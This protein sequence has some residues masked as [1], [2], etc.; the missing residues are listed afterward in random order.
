MP[1]GKGDG[2]ELGDADDVVP[3]AVCGAVGFGRVPDGV[4]EDLRDA[5]A[6]L[7]LPGGVGAHTGAAAVDAEGCDG[8][9]D[10]G[11][12][13]EEGWEGG[14]EMHGWCGVTVVGFVEVW[15]IG[16]GMEGS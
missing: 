15:G 7:V 1:A 4:A 16:L 12:K 6:G 5:F 10:E 8:A 3:V 9:K 11:G 13:V 2:L 14:G